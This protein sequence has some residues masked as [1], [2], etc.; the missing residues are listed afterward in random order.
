MSSAG[1]NG[2]NGTDVGATLA[3][4]EIAFKTNAGA[5][6]GIPIGNAGEFLK[7]NSGATG[8][9]YGAVSSDCVKVA[10]FSHSGSNV[11][12]FNMDNIFSATYPVYKVYLTGVLHSSTGASGWIRVIKSDGSNSTSN[13]YEYVWDGKT[14]GGSGLEAYSTGASHF[15]VSND[16]SSDSE[17]TS[18]FEFTIYRPYQTTEYKHISWHCNT[19][20]NNTS[21]LRYFIGSGHWKTYGT[22]IRGLNYSG[23]GVSDKVK[24][25]KAV[26]YGFKGAY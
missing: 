10:E 8:Y 5:V 7:V 13:N 20:C 15:Q 4:K 18:S 1:T 16:L 26:V 22:A 3:N 19:Y 11:T 6:D 2:T 17:K 9:E 14:S 25:A 23:Q 12:N 24:Q 21:N